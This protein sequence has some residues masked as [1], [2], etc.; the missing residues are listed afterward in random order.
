MKPDFFNDNVQRAYPLE[1]TDTPV[2]PEFAIADFGSIIFAGAGFNEASHRIWLDWVR[3]SRNK[4]EF[5]YRCDAPQLQSLALIFQFNVSDPS[6]TTAFAYAQTAVGSAQIDCACD[7]DVFV[8]ELTQAAS[9]MPGWTATG[10]A[11]LYQDASGAHIE[12]DSIVEGKLIYRDIVVPDNTRLRL[13]LDVTEFVGDGQSVLLVR[14]LDDAETTELGAATVH[15]IGTTGLLVDTGDF[16][17]L[18]VYIHL[19]NSTY[20]PMNVVISTLRL[21]QCTATSSS[22]FQPPPDPGLCNEQSIWEG[23]MVIGDMLQLLEYLTNCDTVA[24][25]RPAADVCQLLLL[26][27]TGLTDFELIQLALDDAF[28]SLQALLPQLEL[29][30]S[31]AAYNDSLTGGSYDPEG[32]FD[33]VNFATYDIV[34]D[35]LVTDLVETTGDSDRGITSLSTLLPDWYARGGNFDDPR[36]VLWVGESSSVTVAGELQALVTTA[37]NAGVAI[38]AINANSSAEGIDSPDPHAGVRQATTLV[39]KTGGMAI[40]RPAITGTEITDFVVK[41]VLRQATYSDRGESLR[42]VLYGPAYVEPSRTQNLSDAH[43]RTIAV[44][45]VERTRASGRDDC[46]ELCWPFE[47]QDVYTVCSCVVGDVDFIDG[48]NVS[49][50]VAEASNSI[51]FNAGPGLGLGAACDELPIS[52]LE[53]PPSGRTT[54]TGSLRCT[55]VITQVNGTAGRKLLIVGGD[56]VQV[57]AIPEQHRIIIDANLADM[58]YA[59]VRDPDQAVICHYPSEDLCECGPLDINDFICPDPPPGRRSTTTTTQAPTTTTTAPPTTTTTTEA[60]VTDDAWWPSGIIKGNGFRASF[61]SHT[62]LFPYAKR[63]THGSNLPD[64]DMPQ[65][66]TPLVSDHATVN[67]SNNLYAFEGENRI[68]GGDPGSSRTD[69][70]WFYFGGTTHA[71]NGK[72]AITTGAPPSVTGDTYTAFKIAGVVPPPAPGGGTP[73]TGYFQ[74]VFMINGDITGNPY[75]NEYLLNFRV[76]NIVGRFRWYILRLYSWKSLTRNELPNPVSLISP[77]T[78]Y[79]PWLGQPAG[80]SLSPW[81][82]ADNSQ[83]GLIETANHNYSISIDYPFGVQGFM[84]NPNGGLLE[85]AGISYW[86]G[87][88]V[89]PNVRVGDNPG[90]RSM[91]IRQIELNRIY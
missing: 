58:A 66:L 81:L 75:S 38:Y 27:D 47:T 29:R 36:M 42:A 60:P 80:V 67:A 15:E 10:D 33:G 71:T 11:D 12:S 69:D 23:F 56:G 17:T 79:Y 25:D 63:N 70:R 2:I 44:G 54:Y 62:G 13:M 61:W 83:S 6:F 91:E 5:C 32:L 26:L 64:D 76:E 74:E 77:P 53:S 88:G 9:G 72:L 28:V 68:V 46:R 35:F 41:S 19:L 87:F 82:E 24:I 1:A 14:V 45:N 49:I 51:I 21:S 20:S 4:I 37:R 3:R 43:V 86:V 16:T 7:T 48:H 90:L 22:F 89:D 30:I 73:L 78:F 84:I 57:T 31:I 55:E 59:P 18:R 34:Q 8:A 39:A 65:T 85:L 50:Q 52:P 40:H